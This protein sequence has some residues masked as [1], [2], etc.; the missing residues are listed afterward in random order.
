MG[1]RILSLPDDL[2][3]FEL[4]DADF[5]VTNYNVSVQGRAK[6]LNSVLNHFWKRWSKEYSLE[7]QE[8]H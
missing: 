3:Y 1:H 6:H 4:D 5:E 7:L 2:N 8:S